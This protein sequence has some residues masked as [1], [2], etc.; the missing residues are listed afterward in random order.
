MGGL[1]ISATLTAVVTA[2]GHNK[3]PKLPSKTSLAQY[4]LCR[5]LIYKLS[6]FT[7]FFQHFYKKTFD[8]VYKG[9]LDYYFF[10]KRNFPF[11]CISLLS[12]TVGFS[13]NASEEKAIPFFFTSFPSS[14][15]GKPGVNSRQCLHGLSTELLLCGPLHR[16]KGPYYSLNLMCFQ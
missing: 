3:G 7:C 13:P 11:I 5:I 9:L 2:T 8:F 1:L 10:S 6:Q 4:Q 15:C 12:K 16:Y 14:R